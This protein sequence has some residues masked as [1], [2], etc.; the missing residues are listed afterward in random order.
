MFTEHFQCARKTAKFSYSF[1][2][3]ILTATLDAGAGGNSGS[4]RLCDLFEVTHQDE[5]ELGRT[6]ICPSAMLST[7]MQS[8]LLKWV[9]A[10]SES[11]WEGKVLGDPLT[12][13]SL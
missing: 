1:S 12:H 5:V 13:I 9:S 2:H 11:P 4:E 7:T 3:L 6:W 10:F 8:G